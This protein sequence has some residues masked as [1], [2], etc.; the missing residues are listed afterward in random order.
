MLKVLTAKQTKSLDAY[1]I[2]NEPVASIDLM[3]RA[4]RSFVTWFAEKFDSTKRIGIICG[5]G[6]NGGDGLGIAR[7]LYDRNYLVRVWIVRGAVSE[8]ED[9]KTNFKR[10]PSKI[11]TYEIRSDSDKGLFVDC[12]LLIDALFGTGLSRP[13][14]GVYA[15]VIS[16]I[17]QSHATRI[18]IDLPSGLMADSHSTGAV[19]NAHYT[20]SFQLPKLAFLLPE[21]GSAVGEWTTT[22]IGLSKEFIADAESSHFLLERSDI[23]KIKKIRSRF[24]HK[25]TYGKALLIAGSYGKMGAAVLASRA[26]MHSGLGLLTVHIPSSGYDIIQ[27]AVPEA[28]A[29]IDTGDKTFSL[30]PSIESYDSIGVGPGIG[31]A[32]ETCKAFALL[33]SNYSRPLVI[34]ADGLNILAN[35]REFIHLIP[36]GSILTPHPKEFERLVGNSKDD[37]ERLE[38]LKKFADQTKCVIILKGA[39]TAIA[40]PQGQVYFNPTGNPGMATGGS[41]D[42]LTGLLT[43]LLAQNY[44]SLE[45]A[46]LGVYLHGLAGDLAARAKGFESMIASDLISFTSNA[47]LELR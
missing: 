27:T 36:A 35:N 16:C 26:A 44:T 30:L 40:S 28:M 38:N 42:V 37:F 31:M 19:V 9:F 39:F 24:S 32:A 29:S 15:Q 34:D 41:G 8:S 45:A 12:D 23:L 18:A 5:T 46:Q 4:C 7:V 22:N 20:V 2:A 33:L 3:E 11:P 25:G 10:L 1:T 13:L 43:G 17:N 21:N 6:N 14:D 47:F